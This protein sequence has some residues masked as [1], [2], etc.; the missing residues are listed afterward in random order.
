MLKYKVS[1]VTYI[2][3]LYYILYTQP[4]TI[5]PHS[6]QPK[7]TKRLDAHAGEVEPPTNTPLCF[8]AVPQMISKEGFD[9]EV[10]L[11]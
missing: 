8:A 10:C 7:Q 11:K 9:M 2:Y 1:F 3:Q 5:P 4:K 6:K